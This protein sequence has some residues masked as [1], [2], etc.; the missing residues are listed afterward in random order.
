MLMGTIPAL[1]PNT[2]RNQQPGFFLQLP[3]E[4]VT[5]ACLLVLSVPIR[6]GLVAELNKW[7]L[8]SAGK[9]GK[10][11]DTLVPPLELLIDEGA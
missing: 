5:L 1:I 8:K 2:L 4:S 11:I 3:A 10:H 9:A 7:L 6:A